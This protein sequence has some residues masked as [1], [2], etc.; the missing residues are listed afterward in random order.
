MVYT[1]A[2]SAHCCRTAIIGQGPAVLVAGIRR[3]SFEFFFF[4]FV[5][6]VFFFFFVF[7]FFLGFFFFFFKFHGF[8]QGN[9][10]VKVLVFGIFL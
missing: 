4:C 7:F 3:K 6:L 9:K 10:M 5:F 8:L 1:V 2:P